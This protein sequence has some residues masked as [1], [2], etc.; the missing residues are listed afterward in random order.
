MASVQ[1]MP[2][3]RSALRRI[4]VPDDL[5]AVTSIGQEEDPEPYG[6]SRATLERIWMAAQELYRS[7][8]HPALQLCLRR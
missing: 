7:G 2:S 8:V 5:E 4:D 1:R 3:L 6:L